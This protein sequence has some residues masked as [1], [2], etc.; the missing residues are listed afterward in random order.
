MGCDTRNAWQFVCYL[1]FNPRTHRG[2]RRLQLR[3][4][5]SFKIFQSTHPSWGATMSKASELIGI[6]IFQSTHPSWGA[7]LRFAIHLVRM[8]FQ[9]THPSW[10]AT[11][12]IIYGFSQDDISIHAPIVGCDQKISFLQSLVQY[13]NPRT[14]R[15]VRLKEQDQTLLFLK[16]QSTH[17]SWGATL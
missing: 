16:F 4:V 15:G 13:F 2:V 9:S 12:A 3:K 14:H 6:I 10:G 8:L 1:Y 17:P 5:R 11:Y 7:T